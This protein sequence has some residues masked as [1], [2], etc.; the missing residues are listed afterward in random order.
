MYSY[1][2]SRLK[3]GLLLIPVLLWL[4]PG[5]IHAA[6]TRSQLNQARSLVGKHHFDQSRSLYQALIRQSSDDKQKAVLERELYYVLPYYE[7]DYYFSAGALEKAQDIVVSAIR[8]NRPHPGRVKK[9]KELG[10]RILAARQ[11]DSKGD[12]PDER[13]VAQQIGDIFKDYQRSHHSYPVDYDALNQLLPPEKGLLRWY[14]VV[15]YRGGRQFYRIR[16][17]NRGDLQQVLELSG[18]SLLR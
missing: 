10:V 18:G 11:G 14:E 12:A 4:M 2:H 16:L 6:S 7:A 8:R 15:D 13:A 17:R 1:R 3:S 9:L 5:Q